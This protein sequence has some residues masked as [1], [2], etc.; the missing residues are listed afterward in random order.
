MA[1]VLPSGRYLP[2]GTLALMMPDR[3]AE[4]I[5][6]LDLATVLAIDPEFGV[7]RETMAAAGAKGMEAVAIDPATVRLAPPIPR[8]GKIV[9]VGYNYLDHIREQVHSSA[10][11]KLS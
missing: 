5:G 7:L 2:L 11:L 4:E 10:M 1:V 3:L 6:E 9:G 8:P